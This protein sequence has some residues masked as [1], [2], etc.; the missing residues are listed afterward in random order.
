MSS[1][2]KSLDSVT[3]G[4]SRFEKDQVLTHDQLNSIS[5]YF[6]DQIRL[7]RVA[8]LGVGIA[9]GLRVSIQDDSVRVTKGFGMTTDGDLLS[10]PSDVVFHKFKPYDESNPRYGPF[11]D[12][13][14]QMV[15]VQQLV[16]D[17]SDPLARPLSA[18]NSEVGSPLKQRVVIALMES[19]RKDRDLCT[20]TDCDNLGADHVCH[21]KLLLVDRGSLGSL[22]PTLPLTPHDA[23]AIL[24]EVVADRPKITPSVD[25]EPELANVYRNAGSAI[26]QKLMR[27]LKKLF[28]ACQAFLGKQVFADNPFGVWQASLKQ[29]REVEFSDNNHQNTQYFYDFLKDLTETYNAFRESLFG[30]KTWCL[31]GTGHFPKHL[32]LGLL[33]SPAEHRTDLYPSPLVSPTSKQLERARFLA[34]KLDSQ[35]AGFKLPPASGNVLDSLRVTPSRFEDSP[36]EDR[37]IPFYYNVPADAAIHTLWNGRLHERGMVTHN[38]S[39][40][41]ESY[42]APAFVQNPF[43]SQIGRFDFFRIEGHLGLQVDDVVKALDNLT[44]KHQLPFCVRTVLLGANR[45]RVRRKRGYTDLHRFH[46]L[47]RQDLIHQLD[48][49]ERFS[50]TFQGQLKRAIEKHDVVDDDRTGVPYSQVADQKVVEIKNKAAKVRAKAALSYS[51]FSQ[52]VD[53]SWTAELNDVMQAAGEFKQG[54]G[55]VIATQFTTPFDAII[56]N[57]HI[58]WLEWLGKIIQEND[59]QKDERQLLKSFLQEH[60]GLEHFAGVVRGGTFVI[61]YNDQ[62][63]VVADFMLPYYAP[64]LQEDEPKELPLPRP[65]VIPNFV[66]DKGVEVLP[67]REKYFTDELQIFRESF[68]K[69]VD[70][71]IDVQNRVFTVF[72]DSVSMMGDVYKGKT[73]GE[74][75]VKTDRESLIDALVNEASSKQRM[76]D[77]LRNAATK[78]N[79][80]NE[81]QARLRKQ[82]ER[83]ENELAGTVITTV[84]EVAAR[85][86]A[87]T[88]GSE[89]YDAVINVSHRI[90]AISDADVKRKLKRRLNQIA[91]ETQTK[92]PGLKKLLDDIVVF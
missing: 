44:R 91:E 84:E 67:S 40:H 86:L 68:N 30:D 24:G 78:P 72:K 25:T 62:G 41:A 21:L 35:I 52:D 16:A 20:G 54:L 46:Y 31:P 19:F 34:R 61:V 5:D 6:D 89:A 11:F 58:R 63:R 92:N 39:Y 26:L 23:S 53:A 38:Y 64:E 83:T 13:N 27:E 90:G 79:L 1:V 80:P 37:A 50:E 75:T 18:F 9:C 70:E 2:F 36:L 59:E 85:G 7:S 42:S 10:L 60:P 45:R 66:L 15:D 73:P 77:V 33:N 48:D 71:R 55:K 51:A 65:K 47:L 81:T 22:E 49:N 57:T 74:V 43:T 17:D 3:T 87:V 88:P 32:L 4:Y 76:V 29:L 12:S 28:P 82:L 14:N 56:S 8:L 69:Q